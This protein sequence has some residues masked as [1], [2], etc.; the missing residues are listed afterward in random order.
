[1]ATSSEESQPPERPEGE[2]MEKGE[3]AAVAVERETGKKRKRDAAEVEPGIPNGRH[4]YW[5]TTSESDHEGDKPVEFVTPAPQPE[6][7]KAR[8]MVMGKAPD[9]SPDHQLQRSGS[10]RPPPA[11]ARASLCP[12]KEAAEAAKDPLEEGGS[13]GAGHEVTKKMKTPT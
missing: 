7:R 11:E 9:Q 12:G 10:R 3:E 4:G 13:Q 2:E 1:M 5:A 6:I 8:M